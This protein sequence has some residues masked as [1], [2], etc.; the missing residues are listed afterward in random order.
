MDSF[1]ARYRAA[2]ARK[3]IEVIGAKPP[4][5]ATF[6]NEFEP[7]AA[8]WSFKQGTAGIRWLATF[9]EWSRFSARA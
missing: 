3:K 8:K 9:L 2:Q 5:T 4:E 6:Y 7:D 1:P